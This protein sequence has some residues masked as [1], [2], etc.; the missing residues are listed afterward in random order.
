LKFKPVV[1]LEKIQWESKKISGSTKLDHPLSLITFDVHEGEKEFSITIA[2]QIGEHINLTSHQG[3]MSFDR[4]G[5]GITNFSEVFPAI[6]KIDLGNLEVKKVSLY[7]DLSSIEIFINDG[8]RVMTEVI[9]PNAPYNYV[10]LEKENP[11][12]VISKVAP[13]LK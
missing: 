6:H 12:M 10:K 1:E 5:S 7:L 8:E 11:E 3:T 13:T 9:F 4:T 2:N